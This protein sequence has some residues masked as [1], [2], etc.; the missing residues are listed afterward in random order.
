MDE[1]NIDELLK[2]S[3]T[4]SS[5]NES[6]RK[7]ILPCFSRVDLIDK[8]VLFYQ[9]DP[10]DNVYIL[11]KGRLSAELVNAEGKTSIIGYIQKGETV[12]EMGALANEPR[13]LTVK[14]IDN[15]TLL[16]LSTHDFT[17]IG[18]EHPSVMFAVIRPMITRTSTLIQKLSSEKRNKHIV[19]L[20]AN[21][22]VS[23]EAIAL[24]LQD[25]ADIYKSTLIVSDYDQD[26]HENDKT[27][28]VH[29]KIK[30]KISAT[31]KSVHRTL[32]ILRG[33]D[34]PLA[35]YALKRANILYV[36]AYGNEKPAIDSD[37]LEVIANIRPN[38]GMPLN[39]I[40]L[41]PDHTVMPQNTI[42]WLKLADFGLHHHIRL[43]TKGDIQRLFRFIRGKAV[44]VVLGGG[45]TR[46]W[47]HIGAIK[48]IQAAKI[49]IDIIGGT[50]VGALIAGIYAVN[51]TYENIYKNFLQMVTDSKY[52]ISWRN[53][54]WPIIS[55]FN[56]KKYTDSQIN[57]FREQRIEDLWLPYFCI[58]SNLAHCSEEVHQTGKCWENIRAST[59]IPG[60][61][62]PMVLNGEIHVDGSLLNNLPVDVMRKFI[63]S[64]GKVIAIE[65]NDLVTDEIKYNFPPVQTFMD[66]FLNK[67][68][69]KK[70]HYKYPR[71][72]DTFL[73]SLLLG[74]L[75]R[76]RQN[77]LIANIFVSLNLLKF[78][79]LHSNPDEGE[80]LVKIGFDETMKQ[81]E[82]TKNKNI[83][84]A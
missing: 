22:S 57:F 7:R 55:I 73:R 3:N 19:L 70:Y 60:L 11:I 15:A 78:R 43:D 42:G 38:P 16:K 79:M 66:I 32:Y 51:P 2:A 48:A 24:K 81:I 46:G 54:T 30:N 39:L 59:A 9:G 75:W 47:A 21:S 65:L 37:L 77:A 4:F 56:A 17:V 34:S 80:Q 69:I 35:K 74:S 64:R 72:I 27:T 68:R 40:L 28:S 25:F 23:V 18:H 29:D 41:Y 82:R 49:P 36:T 63:G 44:G 84:P 14:A 53:L 8:E 31:K 45:G 61:I 67:L 20:P 12:G 6:E 50:S 62:P 52:T 58:T 76:N 13:T 26:F 83:S 5:L 33:L 1:I 71:L 10:S